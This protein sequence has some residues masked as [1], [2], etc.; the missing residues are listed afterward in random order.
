M[1]KLVSLWAAIG[2]T[3]LFVGCA[4]RP[5][6]SNGKTAESSMEAEGGAEQP[7]ESP[8]ESS[9]DST[10]KS[11]KPDGETQAEKKPA[12]EETAGEKS[13][14]PKQPDTDDRAGSE[15]PAPM[16]SV[17]SDVPHTK[18]E[19]SEGETG[20]KKKPGE[21]ARVKTGTVSK[22]GEK[23]PAEDKSADDN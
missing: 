12:K 9:Q 3:F 14:A 20:G 5:P 11:N 13:D 18:A 6:G 1:K 19:T 7:K 10:A 23:Q 15:T 16:P 22:D 17:P 2:A 21:E 8:S 4:E